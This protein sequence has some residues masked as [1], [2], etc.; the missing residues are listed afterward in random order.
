MDSSRPKKR[1]TQAQRDTLN[2][3]KSL[4]QISG[5]YDMGH[6]GNMFTCTSCITCSK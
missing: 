3:L 2:E 5:D 4:G 1:M 6:A